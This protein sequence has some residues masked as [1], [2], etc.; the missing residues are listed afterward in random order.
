MKVLK[1][2]KC[3]VYQIFSEYLMFVVTTAKIRQQFFLN[4]MPSKLSH[5]Q[6]GL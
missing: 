3:I 2:G 4:C 5:Y 1:G 6:G